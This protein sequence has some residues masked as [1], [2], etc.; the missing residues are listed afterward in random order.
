MTLAHQID[1]VSRKHKQSM[2]SVRLER[3]CQR[4]CGIAIHISDQFRAHA[5]GMSQDPGFE[6]VLACA[7]L[8]AG[9]LSLARSCAE[10]VLSA[11]ERIE[12]AVERASERIHAIAVLARVLCLQGFAEQALHFAGRAVDDA[13]LA[14]VPALLCQASLTEAYLHLVCGSFAKASADLATLLE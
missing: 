13:R 14:A 9:R 8:Y 3:V 12:D 7:H 5:P 2:P 4:H 1:L 10:S 6:R 11:A